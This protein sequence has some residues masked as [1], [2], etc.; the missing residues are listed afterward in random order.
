MIE[1]SSSALDQE[2]LS[3]FR[4]L[5]HL[6]SRAS[7]NPSIR[8]S[9]PPAHLVYLWVFKNDLCAV[10]QV[11]GFLTIYKQAFE[12][13]MT[14]SK[15]GS[16]EIIG[17]PLEE[18]NTFN[19]YVMD[20][21][22][23]IWRN[24]ALNRQDPNAFGCMVPT[25]LLAPIQTYLD[26]LEENLSLAYLFSLSY[27]GGLSAASAACFIELE[28][29][30]NP[31]R[32]GVLNKRLA[33]PVSQRNLGILE[34]QGGLGFSWQNYRLEMLQWLDDRGCE[35]VGRLMRNTMKILRK[36]GT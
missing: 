4:R 12:T 11:C 17:Y 27:H 23:M 34:K 29:A 9:L 35:G 22:N 3:F 31:T 24:R 14:A 20:V 19:G 13:S 26:S 6:F 21:C 30:E 32:D 15:E 18:V 16:S 2:A 7:L 36:P 28:D 33:G 8:I 10:S 25:K 1:S 5:A